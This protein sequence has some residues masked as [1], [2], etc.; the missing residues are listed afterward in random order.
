MA[1]RKSKFDRILQDP[2]RKNL[3]Q[4]IFELGFYSIKE[5]RFAKEYLSRL[6]Y[7]KNSLPFNNFL[8]DA[9]IG[10]LQ[11]SRILHSDD[12]AETL[13]NKVKFYQFCIKNNIPTPKIIVY[14]DKYRFN[15]FKASFEIKD[16]E[17]FK[18]LAK[19]WMH[20]SKYQSIFIKPVDG[21]GGTNAYRLDHNTSETE[22]DTVF[23]AIT[24]A[25]Y[26]IQETII[27]HPDVQIVSPYSINTLRVDTYKPLNE[28]SR[29][30]S[31]LMRFGREGFVVD[32]PGSSGGFFV[33][34]DMKNKC[35]KAPGLQMMAVGNHT[36]LEHPD[37]HV[38]LDKHPVPYLEEAFALVN[39]ACEL[40]GDRLI[41]WDVCIGPEGPII[42]EGNHNYHM[43]MQEVAYGGYRK[44][45][46]FMRV[47]AEENIRP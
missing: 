20:T 26:I 2:L 7:R 44:H 18:A 45:P 3:V 40:L 10:K 13:I 35:L 5:R 42:I 27:Q 46:D 29:V 14:N 9:E 39:H 32:N 22:Y 30:M 36:Y 8:R 12:S 11:L 47:L 21:K 43:V 37:T 38:V 25:H 33:P 31:A 24:A 16:V 4:I 28:P 1:T 41:G 34:V 15:D 23:N 6:L 19:E 17:T